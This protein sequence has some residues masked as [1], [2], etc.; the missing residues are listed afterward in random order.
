MGSLQ[1]AYQSIYYNEQELREE[2]AEFCNEFFF[3]TEEETEYFVEELFKDEDIV[4]EFFDD[5][6]EFSSEFQLNEDTYITEIRSALIKQGLKLGQGLLKKA[7]PAVRG[8]SAKTLTK[9]GIQ[10]GG[11]TQK[12]TKLAATNKPALA[13]QT[14][15]I[16]TARAERQIG[17][18][19]TQ[20]PNK[21]LNMLQQKR[22]SRGLPPAGQTTAGTAKAKGERGWLRHKVAVDQ[23]NTVATA[24]MKT[25]EASAKA[26]QKAQKVSAASSKLAT[27]AKGTKN[28]GPAIP[29]TGAKPNTGA[30]L[31]GTR[32]V[33]NIRQV[34]KKYGMDAPAPKP[35]WGGKPGNP[36]D[37]PDTRIVKT[38]RVSK[39]KPEPAKAVQAA[40]PQ[41]PKRPALPGGTTPGSGR[42]DFV[43]SGGVSSKSGKMGSDGVKGTQLPGYTDASK[44][45][46]DVGATKVSSART[47]TDR[48]RE[49]VRNLGKNKGAAAIALT[50]AGLGYGLTNAV[51]NGKKQTVDTTDYETKVRRDPTYYADKDSK[52]PPAPK[53]PPASKTP[54]APAKPA[55]KTPP[56]KPAPAPLPSGS[57]G[58]GNETAKPT[59]GNGTSKQTETRRKLS[60]AEREVRELMGMRAAS[61]ERQGKKGEAKALRDKISKKYSGYED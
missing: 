50:T 61:L 19:K 57:K 60:R 8:M 9:Q 42:K 11:L 39:S 24:F 5:V 34:S 58:S 26:A 47:K 53:T 18:P 30:G 14:R 1:Q 12:G 51:L 29:M 22:A 44:Q 21:Y 41:A 10:A 45:T 25:L 32:D 6:L 59:G 27:A 20:E 23:A 38:S 35:A 54:P 56:A 40:L 28:I 43:S 33:L 55:P 52:T 17:I 16:Q 4:L 7:T 13:T 36:W 3:D 49:A 46:V 31:I 37:T 48:T 2:V 15:A